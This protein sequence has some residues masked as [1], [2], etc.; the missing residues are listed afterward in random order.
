MEK[1]EIIRTLKVV[2][3]VEWV[4]GI[5]AFISCYMTVNMP[6]DSAGALENIVFYGLFGTAFFISGTIT[7]LKRFDFPD[8]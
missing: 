4:I 1:S 2:G 3:I 6:Y 8:L 5:F 7:Y